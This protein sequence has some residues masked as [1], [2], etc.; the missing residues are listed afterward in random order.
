[1]SS[2]DKEVREGTVKFYADEKLFGFLIDDQTGEEIYVP[3][4]GL[5]DEIKKGTK[6]FYTPVEGEKGTEAIDVKSRKKKS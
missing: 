4:A 2:D 1:M 5:I 6:V 3:V